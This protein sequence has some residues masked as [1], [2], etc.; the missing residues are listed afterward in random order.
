MIILKKPFFLHDQEVKEKKYLENE[1]SFSAEKKNF[2]FVIFK[3]LSLK[4]IKQISSEGVTGL[5]MNILRASDKS[6]MQR[7]F[8][9]KKRGRFIARRRFSGRLYNF[10]NFLIIFSLM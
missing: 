3:G 2:F 5:S 7:G 6:P 4:I 8:F 9:H 1:N 10:C